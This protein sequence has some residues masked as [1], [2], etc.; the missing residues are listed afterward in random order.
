MWICEIRDLVYNFCYQNLNSPDENFPLINHLDFL[1]DIN[2]LEES[3]LQYDWN[4]NDSKAL[5]H[6]ALLKYTAN[7][8]YSRLDL[9]E[10][11]SNN[12]KKDQILETEKQKFKESVIKY[13]K[14]KFLVCCDLATGF[15]GTLSGYGVWSFLVEEGVIDA[16]ADNIANS[17]YP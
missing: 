13:A 17:I 16:W 15:G 1:K 4:V 12:V 10:L 11:F 5:K 8:W 9:D 3:M 6:L 7:F 14:Y 2:T